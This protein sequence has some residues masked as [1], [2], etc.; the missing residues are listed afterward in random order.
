MKLDKL[1]E[2]N[3]LSDLHKREVYS[4]IQDLFAALEGRQLSGV[5][6]DKLN[7]DISAINS[8][9]SNDQ[10][11]TKFIKRRQ[12][13]IVKLL[14]KEMKIV[15]KNYYRNLWLAVGMAAFGMPIGV[16]FGTSIGNLGLIGVGIPVGMAIG[17][18]IGTTLDKK[19][20]AE[21]RQLNLEI[22]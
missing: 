21:N 13:A 3:D 7:Q 9:S 19:A 1:K 10:D 4:R 8:I 17:I 15:P 6:V 20:F 22:K 12:S 16:A 14:E 11:F 2:R 18:A 5:V